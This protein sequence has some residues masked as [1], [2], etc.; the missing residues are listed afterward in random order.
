M[1]W[2][3]GA[4]LT[5]ALATLS[6]C[7]LFGSGSKGV[8][9]TDPS[10]TLTVRSPAFAE[11]GPIPRD[12]TCKGANIS[13]P[14]QWSGVPS[15]ARALAL[16]VSDPDAPGGTYT[17]WID[18]NIDPSATSVG[19]GAVPR[20]GRQAENSAGHARYDGPCPPSGTHHY[21]FTVYVLRS[22]STLPDGIGTDRALGA[23]AGKAIARG[24]LTGTFAAT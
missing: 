14:L 24:T 2:T 16:V 21:R 7:G 20:G 8:P 11:G 9:E 5:V 12:F 10:V 23:I 3:T 17:H 1:R 15:T 18:F 22:P 13:P 19:A 4:V 6:G